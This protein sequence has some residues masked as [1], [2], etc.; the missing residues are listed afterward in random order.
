MTHNTSTTPD[1]AYMRIGGLTLLEGCGEA[2]MPKPANPHSPAR[3]LRPGRPPEMSWPY[4][5]INR[6]LTFALTVGRQTIKYF[7]SPVSEWLG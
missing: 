1:P 2:S 7:R 3:T 4:S 6:Q 5:Q